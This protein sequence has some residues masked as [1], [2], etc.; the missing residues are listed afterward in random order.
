MKNVFLNSLFS[1]SD[2]N[3]G[4]TSKDAVNVPDYNQINGHPLTTKLMQSKILVQ[5]FI[6]WKYFNGNIVLAFGCLR[7]E[8]NLAVV[9]LRSNQNG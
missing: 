2:A 5:V 9:S 6:F 8:K 3:H 7:D 4:M 1:R